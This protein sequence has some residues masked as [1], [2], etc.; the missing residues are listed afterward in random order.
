MLLENIEVYRTDECASGWNGF[1][2]A[3]S[4]SFFLKVNLLYTIL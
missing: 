1:S 4:I 2:I 3:N